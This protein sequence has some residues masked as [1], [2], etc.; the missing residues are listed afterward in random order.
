M[1]FPLIAGW[2]IVWARAQAQ[3]SAANAYMAI[4]AFGILVLLVGAGFL[5]SIKDFPAPK[6]TLFWPKKISLDWKLFRVFVTAS[7]VQMAVGSTVMEIMTLLFLGDEGVLGTFKSILAIIVGVAIYAIG[8]K[9][10]PKDRFKL[11]VF[12]AFPLLIS[13][14]LL[15]VKFNQLTL[16]F[17]IISM[18][19]SANIFWFVYIPIMSK[20]T[21]MQGDGQMKDNYVYI[22][23]HELFINLGRITSMLFILFVFH[24]LD[25]MTG[26]IV[27]VLTGAIARVFGLFAAKKLVE[28]Q[29]L[30]LR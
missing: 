17:Y 13:A 20:A 8:R 26:L 15:L 18:I 2:L 14:L 27:V 16:M 29:N 22:L 12:S 7:T 4:M 9:M 28:L 5:S 6:I 10:K 25:N 3:F 19:L 11:L 30:E 23:D 24:Y 21:E 1:I